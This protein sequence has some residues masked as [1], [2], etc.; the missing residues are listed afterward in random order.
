MNV[1]SRFWLALFSANFKQIKIAFIG[2]NHFP[3]SHVWKRS[4]HATEIGNRSSPLQV[5]AYLPIMLHARERNN[6]FGFLNL[7]QGSTLTDCK[8]FQSLKC[9]VLSIAAF[10]PALD[11]R[12]PPYFLRR[13]RMCERKCLSE[14]IRLAS[15]YKV[16]RNTK[17]SWRVNTS[18]DPNWI[19]F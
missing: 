12:V 16:R 1:R 7:Q 2:N 11:S 8:G 3:Q 18:D 13:R 9:N 10:G 17:R 14:T 19:Q 6:E 4:S 5:F 15:K